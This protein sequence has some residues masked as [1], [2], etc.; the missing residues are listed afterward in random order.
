M[1]T[2]LSFKHRS[3]ERPATAAK[4][5]TAKNLNLQFKG[6]VG[7]VPINTETSTVKYLWLQDAKAIL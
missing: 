2:R 5:P 6:L 7:G 4:T 1:T 3:L